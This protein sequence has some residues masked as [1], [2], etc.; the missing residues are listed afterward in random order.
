MQQL[1]PLASEAWGLEG[2]LNMAQLSPMLC[3]VLGRQRRPRNLGNPSSRSGEGWGP[4]LIPG[5]PMLSWVPP[6]FL[7]PLG[8]GTSDRLKL[9][10]TWGLEVGFGFGPPIPM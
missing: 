1:G 9:S 7:R 5:I 4:G 8:V 2:E 10:L 3:E 6:I